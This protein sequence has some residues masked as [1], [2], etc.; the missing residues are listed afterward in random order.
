MEAKITLNNYRCFEDSA[1][2]EFVIKEGFT[3]F[4]GPNNSGKSSILKF[5]YEFRSTFE[6]FSSVNSLRQ[7]FNNDSIGF[8]L[9]GVSDKYEVLNNNNSRPLTVRIEIKPDDESDNYISGVIFTANREPHNQMNYRLLCGSNFIQ[10]NP[11]SEPPYINKNG[12]TYLKILIDDKVEVF[13]PQYLLNFMSDMLNT[14]YIAPFRNAINDGAA[15]YFDMKIGTSFVDQWNGWKN[16]GSREQSEKAID[17]Q[18]YI[19]NL[20]GYRTLEINAAQD[21]KSLNIVINSKSYKLNDLGAGFAQFIL[22]FG[23]AAIK[24]PSYIF[25]DEPES[26]LHPSLQVRF[27]T[28]LESFASKGVVFATHSIGLAR[29]L[30][31]SSIYSCQMQQ[32]KSIVKQFESMPNCAEFLRDMGFYSFKTMGFEKLLF[33]EGL[34]DM[35]VIQ[36]FLRKTGKD[37]NILVFPLGGDQLARGGVEAEISELSRITDEIYFLVDSEKEEQDGQPK[38][39]RVAFKELC[40]RIGFKIHL[41]ERRAIENYFTTE[42]VQSVCGQ[43]YRALQPYERLRDCSPCWSKSSDGEIARNMSWDDIKDTDIGHFISQL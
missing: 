20:F 40:E 21:T 29:A 39:E 14:L 32:E 17:T 35:R 15:Q 12:I 31:T 28:N 26:N 37:S 2:A 7:R 43:T 19:R 3:S 38:Q 41:T 27:L 13:N 10:V 42:A 25:I 24:K 4:I 6:L 34:S 23:N 11:Q 36:Q 30:A 22:V 5:L 8:S 9:L 18:D 33:V 1:P 16:G